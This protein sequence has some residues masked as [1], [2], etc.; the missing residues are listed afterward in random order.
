MNGF[1]TGFRRVLIPHP[2]RQMGKD[3]TGFRTLNAFHPDVPDREDLSRRCGGK[4]REHRGRRRAHQKGLSHK[5]RLSSLIIGSLPMKRMKNHHFRFIGKKNLSQ[6]SPKSLIM[7]LESATPIKRSSNTSPA[8]CP[9][10]STLSLGR[11]P[12]TIS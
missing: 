12:V 2:K 6:F 4:R 5:C 9:Q 1:G 8:F 10:S 7:S 11:R 3:R